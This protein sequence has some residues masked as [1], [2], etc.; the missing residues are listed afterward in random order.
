MK[1]RHLIFT[2]LLAGAAAV[3]TQQADNTDRPDKKTESNKPASLMGSIPN[4]ERGPS[5]S[6]PQEKMH[7]NGDRVSHYPPYYRPD[8]GA[9]SR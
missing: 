5:Y 4:Q 2:I 7:E 3:S 9:D 6:S 1:I 8:G